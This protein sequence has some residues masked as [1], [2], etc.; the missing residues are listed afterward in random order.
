VDHLSSIKKEMGGYLGSI[1]ERLNGSYICLET[2]EYE[3]DVLI[4]KTLQLE[5]EKLR[6]VLYRLIE[7]EVSDFR[8]FER[9]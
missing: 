6:N 9:R 4:D 5:C 1:K 2:I 3:F 8:E 7:E